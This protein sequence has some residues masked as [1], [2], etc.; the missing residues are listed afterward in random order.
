MM[1]DIT[2][3]DSCENLFILLQGLS[4]Y[5]KRWDFIPQRPVKKAYEQDPEKEKQWF[6]YF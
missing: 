3:A 1:E 4:D 5:L 6:E 2:Q